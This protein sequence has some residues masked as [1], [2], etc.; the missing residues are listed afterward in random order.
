MVKT[1]ILWILAVIITLSSMLYQRKTGPNHPVKGKETIGDSQIDFILEKSHSGDTDQ[2]IVITAPD[3]LIK[4]TLV[5][6]RFKTNDEWTKVTMVRDGDEL[7][8]ALPNQPPAGKLDYHIE[9]QK[10][11]SEIIVPT[12][13]SVITRFNGIVPNWILGLHVIFMILGMLLSTRTG[14]EALRKESNIKAFVYLTTAFLF[15]GGIILGPVVQQFAFGAYWTGFPFGKDLTD[16]KT[17]IAMIS[18]II[19]I[20]ALIKNKKARGWIFAASLITLIIYLI[21]HSL[22]GS[23]LD[24]SKMDTE[25]VQVIN[26]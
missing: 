3:T 13:K 24:Y 11:N 25:Q 16:N 18:W 9:I 22:L 5:Y 23:E 4:G 12:E 19:A 6:K 26:E 2:P 20:F 7:K 17:L 1:V 14:L 21:P 10:E 8:G 15:I